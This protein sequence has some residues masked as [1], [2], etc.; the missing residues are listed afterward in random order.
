M[1]PLIEKDLESGQDVPHVV[2]SGIFSDSRMRTP[3]PTIE[4]LKDTPV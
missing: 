2:L 3:F 1:F 4:K